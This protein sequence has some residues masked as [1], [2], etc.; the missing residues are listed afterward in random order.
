MG[1]PN[2]PQ[3]NSSKRQ[4][5]PMKREA[6]PTD[7]SDN[8]ERPPAENPTSTI[9]DKEEA[10]EV[11]TTTQTDEDVRADTREAQRAKNRDATAER[12]DGRADAHEED[13]TPD[14]RGDKG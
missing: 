8:G 13:P 11:R 4:A 5:K 9:S 7:A 3:T 6:K 10:E 14:E 1:N 2:T 12:Q